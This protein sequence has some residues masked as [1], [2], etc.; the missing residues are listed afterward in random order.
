MLLRSPL[1]RRSSSA[2]RSSSS[3]C[4]QGP[5]PPP[6]RTECAYPP[7]QSW[8]R[9]NARSFP[10]SRGRVPSTRSTSHGPGGVGLLLTRWASASRRFRSSSSSSAF[11]LASSPAFSRSFLLQRETV[12]DGVKPRTHVGPA[13]GPAEHGKQ[14]L[15]RAATSHAPEPFEL[16]PLGHSLL[17]RFPRLQ[18]HVQQKQRTSTRRPLRLSHDTRHDCTDW[19]GEPWLTSLAILSRPAATLILIRRLVCLYPCV[20]RPQPARRPAPHLPVL[21]LLLGLPLLTHAGHVRVLPCATDRHRSRPKHRY[22]MV[23]RSRLHEASPQS[24]DVTGA[25]SPSCCSLRSATAWVIQD[26]RSG[27]DTSVQLSDSR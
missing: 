18:H 4:T 22:R 25:M 6:Q 21:G 19:L 11:R 1:S 14:Q 20:C 24:P 26:D 5:V 13:L 9:R 15:W 16:L 10:P 8:G 7:A 27:R 17:Q 23:L 2:L 3:S 12:Q